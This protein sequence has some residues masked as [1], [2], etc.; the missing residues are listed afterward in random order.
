[1]QNPS[2]ILT[3]KNG[4]AIYDVPATLTGLNGQVI[5]AREDS[6]LTVC[7]GTKDDGSAINFLTA[8]N[9]D[10]LKS[11][12]Q[13]FAGHGYTIINITFTVGSFRLD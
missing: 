5:T 13:V 7:T 9:W 6:T 8:R 4:T 3:S 11:G 10:T 12:E 1:M 2:D